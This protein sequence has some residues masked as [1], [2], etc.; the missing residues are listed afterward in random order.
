[1]ARG[2]GSVAI[3]LAFGYGGLVV[4][5]MAVISAAFYFRTVGVLAHGV[6]ANLQSISTRLA[7]L[8]KAGGA[9]AVRDEIVRLLGDGQDQDTEDCLLMSP[10][11]RKL[12]GNLLA[13]PRDEV[14]PG[15]P[16]DRK[17]T[18]NGR[19]SDSRLR[20]K[21]DKGFTPPLLRTLRGIGYMMSADD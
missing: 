14:P 12:A 7:T 21:I 4:G 9:D 19:S 16:S 17:V 6:D 11:G 13:P 1:M 20:T 3:R 8:D 5:S 2:G 15:R 18:R 10:D